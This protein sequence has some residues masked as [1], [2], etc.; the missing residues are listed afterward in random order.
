M[1]IH[2]SEPEG[3]REEG[4]RGGNKRQIY[5]ELVVTPPKEEPQHVLHTVYRWG[6]RPNGAASKA[7]PGSHTNTQ[8]KTKQIIF[9]TQSPQRSAGHQLRRSQPLDDAE[10]SEGMR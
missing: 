4:V 8:I 6:Q 7:A 10:R 2:N 3:K 5:S 1:N 9:N